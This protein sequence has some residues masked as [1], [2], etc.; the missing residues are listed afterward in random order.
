MVKYSQAHKLS[1]HRPIF[2]AAQTNGSTRYQRQPLQIP[3]CRPLNDTKIT[4]TKRS[5]SMHPATR[6]WA[7]PPCTDKGTSTNCSPHILQ[8]QK[9]FFRAGTRCSYFISSQ[10]FAPVKSSSPVMGIFQQINV[11]YLHD[12][13]SY[14]NLGFKRIIILYRKEKEHKRSVLI[15]FTT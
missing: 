11:F 4:R 5:S 13:S 15:I 3:S 7:A 6:L 14:D 12:F 10:E 9:R 2:N 1:D 8:H